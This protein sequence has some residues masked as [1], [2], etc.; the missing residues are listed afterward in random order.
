MIALISDVHGNLPALEAVLERIDERGAAHVLCLGDTA[1]YYPQVDACCEE[2]ARRGVV[3]LRG[4][5]DEYLV[6][7]TRSGRSAWADLCIEQ[8][9]ATVGSAA[10]AWLA[11][12]PDAAVLG[13]IRA[14]HGGWS[15]HLDEYLWK[16]DES[17]FAGQDGRCFA[18][19]HTHRALVWR[20]REVRYCNPGSV[21]QPRDGD[22]RAS[23]A[24]FDG[25]DFEIERVPYDV[26][27]TRAATAAAGLPP[28]VA[29]NLDV[30]RAIGV[31]R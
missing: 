8:Q 16:V 12:L 23:F 3:A 31:P 5:H 1:G 9:Q 26:A 19:G 18:S 6:A 24:W 21:G 20:G 27:R 30:G 13:P 29:A 17:C 2:L 7:G 22:P 15:D 25:A 14:V 28:E 11:E 10:R 4:N